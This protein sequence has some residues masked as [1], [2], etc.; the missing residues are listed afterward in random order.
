MGL[1]PRTPGSRPEPKADAPPL[2]PPGA[3]RLH[4]LRGRAGLALPE[5]WAPCLPVRAPWGR[6]DLVPRDGGQPPLPAEAVPP[7]T[8]GANNVR[9]TTTAPEAEGPTSWRPRREST[10]EVVTGE[11]HGH[12]LTPFLLRTISSSWEDQV[13]S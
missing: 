12:A 8:R 6:R 5:G 9:D 13:A 4:C 10:R 11:R 1:D 7:N 2:R 3:P